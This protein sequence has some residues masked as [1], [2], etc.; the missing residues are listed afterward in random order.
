MRFTTTR[1]FCLVHLLAISTLSAAAFAQPPGA[2]DPLLQARASLLTGQSRIVVIARDAASANIVALLI[3]QL[4]GALGRPLPIINGRAALVPNASLA[5][6][7]RNPAVQHVALDRLIFGALERTGPTTGAT[8]VRQELGLDG[9]GIGVAVIDSGIT[10]WHDDL[11]DAVYPSQRVDRFVDFVAGS[12][13]PSDEYG[14][15]T[16]VA[17]IIA[18]NGFDSGGAR[19]GIAP[20]SRLIV[21]KVL[22]GSGR[23]RISDVIAAFDYVVT[24]QAEVNIR[25]VNLSVATGVYESYNS[26]P[27]TLAAKRAVDAGIVV[28][29]SAGN[30]GRNSQGSTQYG[31]TTAPGN[32]PWVLTVGASSHMGTIDRSDDT[33]APFSSRGPTAIDRAAKPDLVAP[34]VGIESLSVANST[35]YNRYAAYLLP[36]TASTLYP[37]YLSLS[38]TSQAAPVVT[39]T[40]ALMLQANPALTPNAVKAALQ[41]TAQIYANYDALTQ[42]VGFLNA[43]GAVELAHF[44][45]APSTVPYP[46]TTTWSQQLFWG[47][48]RVTGG[49]LAP[50]ADAWQPG[51]L[52]GG[53]TSASGQPIA[54]GV[55]CSANCDGGSGVWTSWGVSCA[56]PLC[57]TADWSRPGSADIVWGSQCGGS[58]CPS[59]TS[60]GP[61]SDSTWATS[62][63]G[64]TVVWGTSDDGDTVVWGTTCTDPSCEPVVWRNP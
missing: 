11:S 21:L 3:Q 35:L 52:W 26:D 39:G 25:V 17:G 1:V 51:T 53:T 27:L 32:A 12:A 22:D 31:G 8:A 48:H 41:F 9:S 30:A 55:I 34:G 15:G 38:G 13:T 60:W 42:G 19:S 44:L 18:G 24:H 36:G 54:W 5:A 40:V 47:N 62:D 45:A 14:H 49:R 61:S 4:G 46:A 10:A 23:G 63:D 29:A 56:D 33:I 50:D 16:H 59:G 57:T 43:Q 7:A 37:P 2:L 6:L 20:A 58:D 28:V 64:D